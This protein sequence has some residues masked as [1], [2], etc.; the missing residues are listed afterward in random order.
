[1]T[2]D[3]H[4]EVTDDMRL[5]MQTLQ[6]LAPEQRRRIFCWFC[7][8]CGVENPPGKMPCQCWNDE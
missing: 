7:S 3:D 5:A 1:M 4:D 8:G 6:K 2:A